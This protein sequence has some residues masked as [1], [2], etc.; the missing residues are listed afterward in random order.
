MFQLPPHS[1][2]CIYL[3][4]CGWN[5]YQSHEQLVLCSVPFVC[6]GRW[7][8]GT[9]NGVYMFKVQCFETAHQNRNADV[10]R[11]VSGLD[12]D[13][14]GSPALCV[15]VQM[16]ICPLVWIDDSSVQCWVHTYP[17]GV[18]RW[19]IDTACYCFSCTTFIYLKSS[20]W[21]PFIAAKGKYLSVQKVLQESSKRIL[22][23]KHI[24]NNISFDDI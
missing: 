1:Y 8:P 23:S 10:S 14:I 4:R 12:R 16:A 6:W 15:Y 13:L 21:K 3:D 19:V 2:A 7:L 22:I 5:S 20:I 18:N 17:I 9:W 11:C 24:N